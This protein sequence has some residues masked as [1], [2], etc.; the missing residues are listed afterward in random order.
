MVSERGNP[1]AGGEEETY[2]QVQ[3]SR[4]QMSSAQGRRPLLSDK[5]SKEQVERVNCEES[6]RNQDYRIRE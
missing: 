2:L 3:K 6:Y 5:C 4:D 1:A